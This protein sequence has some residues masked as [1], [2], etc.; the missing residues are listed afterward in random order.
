MNEGYFGSEDE[1]WIGNNDLFRLIKVTFESAVKKKPFKIED[2]EGHYKLIILSAHDSN[3]AAVLKAYGFNILEPVPFES[4]IEWELFLDDDK[5][6]KV[7][8]RYN[9]NELDLTHKNITCNDV[10]ECDLD[11]FL[12]FTSKF[13]F[14]MPSSEKC[15][16]DLVLKPSFIDITIW[17]LLGVLSLLIIIV[18][19]F[20]IKQVIKR[21]R[22]R[23][24]T[25]SFK[26]M[27][28]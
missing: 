9:G 11:S 3:L 8:V 6:Y 18:T 14:S 26:F 7:S 22:R 10:G 20:I 2:Q 16:S 13:A 23:D 21:K 12:K 17:V 24:P 19:I 1:I 4:D 15:F 5:K 27:K 28:E 25:E